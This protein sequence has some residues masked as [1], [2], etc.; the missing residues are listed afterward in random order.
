[1]KRLLMTSALVALGF[2]AQAQSADFI[3]RVSADLAAQGYDDVD[4]ET[5]GGTIVFEATR[6]GVEFEFIYDSATEALLETRE[7]AEDDDADDDDAD[8]D[9]D[10]EEDDDDDEDE[11]DEDD[12]DED[13]N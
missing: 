10:S 1:M 11:D 3:D 2:S 6:D 12:E 9:D 5:D 13:D 4:V 8:D 7:E